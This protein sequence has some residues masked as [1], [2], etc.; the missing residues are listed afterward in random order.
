LG[1]PNSINLGE[2]LVFSICTHD[3]DSGILTDADAN[4]LYRLYEDET[5]VP[6]LTG[7]MTK[8]DDT[9]TTGFYSESV[10]CSTANGFDSSKTYTI[11]ITAVVNGS[12]GG[13]SYGFRVPADPL[14]NI[15]PGI[16]ASGTAGSALGRI[17]GGIVTIVSP[18]GPDGLT[19]TLVRGDDYSAT[20]GRAIDWTDTSA[21]W[22]TLTSGSIAFTAK[23]NT[24]NSTLTVAGSIV[25]PT[26][27]NKTVRV[28]LTNAQTSSLKVGN[29]WQYD[30]QATLSNGD[31]VTLVRSNAMT[32]IEDMTV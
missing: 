29:D 30:I 11:Y 20:D 7:T 22:P 18:L 27:V 24:R 23:K 31:I 16:Y 19:L 8:L 10:V 26:G 12:T 9:N 32:V 3:P 4:P 14:G 21:Q 5:T 17:G 28:E 1:L 2:T 15:V 6:L 13:I 25:T